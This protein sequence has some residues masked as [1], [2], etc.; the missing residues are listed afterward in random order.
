VCNFDSPAPGT[1]AV[2]AFHDE[3]GNGKLDRGMFGIPKEGVAASN[4]ARGHM[5]PPKWDDAKFVY[6][7]ELLQLRIRIAY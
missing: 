5:G 2:A 3:N 4:D 7:G 6:K 1:Y